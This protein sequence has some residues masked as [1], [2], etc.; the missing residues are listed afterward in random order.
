MMRKRSGVAAGV[1][2]AVVGCASMA[3][4]TVKYSIQDLGTLGGSTSQSLALNNLGQ[5][6]GSADINSTSF[7]YHAFLWSGGGMSNLGTLGGTFSEGDGINDLGEVVGHSYMEGDSIYHTFIY[8]NGHMTDLN[9]F[10]GADNY[11]WAINSL[12]QVTGDYHGSD[13]NY[14]AYLT[15]GNTYTDLGTLGGVF[16]SASGKAVNATGQVAG[17]VY[18]PFSQESRAFLYSAGSMKDLGTL[19]GPYAAAY[20]INASG[21]VV[22]EASINSSSSH[23]FLY[24]NGTM[25]D[26]GTI[27][28]GSN[29]VALSVND[30]GQV[31][32]TSDFQGGGFGSFVYSNG[33]IQNLQSLID[34]NSGWQIAHAFQINNAGQIAGEGEHS[35]D[36]RAFLLTPVPE[37]SSIALL[38]LGGWILGV[39]RRS[40]R[41]R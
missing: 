13:G 25:T 27:G 31:V 32:G 29:S 6:T 20:G 39:R 24:Q 37:P 12:G 9:L 22:G 1:L 28:G 3:S 40:G 30:L 16:T 23:A 41:S 5:V 18:V 2:T 34:P 38:T 35:G 36:M 15:A 11:G 10:N 7:G 21:A 33:Q 19:G 14:H 4:A 26:L 8:A 17:E